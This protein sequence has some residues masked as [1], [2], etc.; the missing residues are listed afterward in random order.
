MSFHDLFDEIQSETGSVNL[1]LHSAPAAEK[2]IE[3]VRLFVDW[4]T[5]S[6]IRHTKLHRLPMFIFYCTREYSDPVAAFSTVLH[7]VIDQITHSMFECLLVGEYQG[8]ARGNL[9]VDDDIR[10][11]GGDAAGA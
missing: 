11:A 2:R 10:A 5:R 3:Y 6:P 4:D 1:I 8:K 7:S 9:L